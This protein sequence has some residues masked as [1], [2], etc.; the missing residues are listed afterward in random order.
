MLMMAATT[1]RNQLSL[2]PL[3]TPLLLPCVS[4]PA[5][6]RGLRPLDAKKKEESSSEEETEPQQEWVMIRDPHGRLAWY[7][8]SRGFRFSVSDRHLFWIG[9]LDFWCVVFPAAPRLGW[10]CGCACISRCLS[11]PIQV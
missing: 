3:C 11:L 5:P 4:F 6:S 10:W 7:V 2:S 9:F 8:S 1:L